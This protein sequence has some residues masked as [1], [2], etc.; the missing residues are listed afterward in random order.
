MKS[1]KRWVVSRSTNAARHRRIHPGVQGMWTSDDPHFE[2]KYVS[3]RHLVP[4]QARA[5]AASSVWGAARADRQSGGQRRCAMGGIPSATIRLSGR[6]AG[7]VAERHGST[8]AHCGAGPGAILT[9]SDIYRS[10]DYRITGADTSE[11]RARFT[12]SG[13]QIAGD[14][15]IRGHGRQLPG[16]GHRPTQRRRESGGTLGHLEDFTTQV[17][18]RV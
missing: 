15:E 13:E 9:R 1:W 7:G 3:S 4:A 17:A 2:G 8:T 16:A 18:A 14:F 12:G 5:E 11:D 10:H 6:D